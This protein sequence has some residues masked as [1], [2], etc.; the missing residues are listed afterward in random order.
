M[1]FWAS[2]STRSR[3]LPGGRREVA[4]CCDCQRETTFAEVEI[5]EKMSLFSVLTVDE[6][7]SAA[8]R[9][10]ECGALG[11]LVDTDE[12]PDRA[13]ADLD[14][15]AR[16]ELMAQRK[17]RLERERAAQAAAREAS[18][19]RELAAMKQRLGLAPAP[20]ARRPASPGRTPRAAEPPTQRGKVP[21][22]AWW[23]RL[24]GKS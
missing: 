1:W 13:M 11:K 9:C 3:A 24:R 15:R 2:S 8:F 23:D 22:P 12:L 14:L 6:E 10:T 21:R 5:V 7:H 18:A 16:S 17:A 20:P 19:D 4:L